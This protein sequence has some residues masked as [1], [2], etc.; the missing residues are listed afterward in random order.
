MRNGKI[1]VSRKAVIMMEI[2]LEDWNIGFFKE[3]KRTWYMYFL[4][5][6]IKDEEVVSLAVKE[7]DKSVG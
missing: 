5:D 6:Y 4:G 3:E 1:L 2:C 7:H